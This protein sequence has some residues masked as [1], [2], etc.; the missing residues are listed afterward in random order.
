M[1]LNEIYHTATMCGLLLDVD[2]GLQQ[3]KAVHDGKAMA[4][5]AR[6]YSSTYNF[7]LAYR[8]H[9]H[10][11]QAAPSIIFRWEDHNGKTNAGN[12]MTRLGVRTVVSLNMA[13]IPKDPM[14]LNDP[15]RMKRIAAHSSAAVWAVD[16]SGK[17]CCAQDEKLSTPG[18]KI[19]LWLSDF[20]AN[21][22]QLPEDLRRPTAH[23]RYVEQL[24]TLLGPQVSWLILSS[25]ITAAPFR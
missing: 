8:D 25:Y 14:D 17:P 7:L 15:A 24:S 20:V 4:N 10:H 13:A 21:P 18:G 5:V 22:E 3:F 23:V 11:A 12:L 19:G 2:R 6:W 16:D 1:V 9:S